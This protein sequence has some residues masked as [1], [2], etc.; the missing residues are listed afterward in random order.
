LASLSD[1]RPAR[2]H[3]RPRAAASA[4]AALFLA[5]FVLAACGSDAPTASGD[6]GAS[7]TIEG[8]VRDEPLEVGDLTLPQVTA[9]GADTTPFIFRAPEGELLLAA[10]GYTNCPDVCPTTL[11]DIK[12][13]KTTLGDDGD[14][15]SV[16]FTTV[17]PERDTA[18]VVTQYLGSFVTDGHPLRT[19]DPAELDAVEQAFGITS[20]VRKNDDG[21]TDVAHTARSFVIDDQGDVVVEWSFGTDADVMANDLKL[22]LKQT[23]A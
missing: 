8:I 23:E 14:Q 17:D 22:L 19:E 15:I 21:S 16:A 13:A 1:H 3:P 2:R 20:E 11:Y 4:V 12:K 5:A 18:E 7:G 9:D 10:F 6:P